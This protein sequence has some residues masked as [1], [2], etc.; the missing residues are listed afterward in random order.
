MRSDRPVFHAYAARTVRFLG[1]WE[2][3]GW[4]MKVYG[5]SLGPAPPANRLVASAMDAARTVLGQ[6]AVTSTRYGIGYIG[7]HEGRGENLVFV[8]WW[9]NENEIFHH[10]FISSPEAPD[11]LQNVT[12][13]SRIACVWDLAVIE[14]ERRAW[15]QS[16]LARPEAPGF[17]E[18]LR[19]RLEGVL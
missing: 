1:L 14:F 2:H 11:R 3:G 15:I 10:V 12:D 7:I 19:I 5:I 17:E 16:V 4:R 9:G 8:D 13:G 6:P 18:Y